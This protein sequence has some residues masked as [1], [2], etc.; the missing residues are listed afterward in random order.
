[1][2]KTRTWPYH[3]NKRGQYGSA[4]KEVSGHVYKH[5]KVRVHVWANAQGSKCMSC[6]NLILWCS[7]CYFG[8]LSVLT[9]TMIWLTLDISTVENYILLNHTWYLVFNIV[10][11]QNYKKLYH[12]LSLVNYK[13]IKQTITTRS[14]YPTMKQ[15]NR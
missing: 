10:W 9:C 12:Q 5:R 2:L 7:L 6:C 15:L 8:C 13:S 4:T 14:N 11:L 3:F 1:M